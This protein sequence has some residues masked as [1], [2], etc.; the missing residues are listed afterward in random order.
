MN[1]RLFPFLSALL[2]ASTTFAQSESPAIYDPAIALD[3]F[4]IRLKFENSVPLEE[5][6]AVLREQ[7]E[8]NAWSSEHPSWRSVGS[9]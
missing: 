3:P 5:E 8:W 7:S 1:Y 9:S 4:E 2:I 6:Q